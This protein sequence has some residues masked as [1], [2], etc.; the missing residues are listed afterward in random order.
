MSLEQY[1]SIISSMLNQQCTLTKLRAEIEE[2]ERRICYKY[3]KFRHLAYNCRNKKK[4]TKGKLIPQNKFEVIAS[5]VMQC[6]VKEEVKVRR[7]KIIEEEIQCFRCQGVE[8]Y[9]QKCPNIKV[10]KKRRSEEVVHAVSPQKAQQEEKPVCFL[11]RKVQEYYS[12]RGMSPSSLKNLQHSL[13]HI[14]AFVTMLDCKF[15]ALFGNVYN[16]FAVHYYNLT[17]HCCYSVH[18]C[19]LATTYYLATLTQ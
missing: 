13:P 17:V 12:K 6:G 2:R 5:R 7:Q 3:K 9:K 18:C 10:E 19:F 11:Q 15:T 14:T 8:Y 1:N 4:E 16:N